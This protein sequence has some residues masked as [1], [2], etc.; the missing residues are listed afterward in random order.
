MAQHKPIFFFIFIFMTYFFFAI[1]F[2]KKIKKK[3]A[4]A[5]PF[6]LI[7]TYTFVER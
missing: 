5:V 4:Y 2:F 6:F 7:Y 3:W 1:N